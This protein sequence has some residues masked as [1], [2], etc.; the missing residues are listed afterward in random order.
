MTITFI[1]ASIILI[2]NTIV[3]I[4]VAIVIIIILSTFTISTKGSLFRALDGSKAAAPPLRAALGPGAPPRRRARPLR[5]PGAPPESA[6]LE[7]IRKLVK[8]Y[9]ELIGAYLEP[10]RVCLGVYLGS[11]TIYFEPC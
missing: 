7:P 5:G 4:I 11:M 8:V 2:T 9:L 10:M 3:L 1:I 6:R